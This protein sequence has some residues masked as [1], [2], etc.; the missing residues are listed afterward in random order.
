MVDTGGS[1]EYNITKN[2]LLPLFEILHVKEIKTLIITHKDYDHCGEIDNLKKYI[3]IEEILYDVDYI[4]I[5]NF[6]FKNLNNRNYDS[7]NDNSLV[8]YGIYDSMHIFLAGDISFDVEKDI[9]KNY[10]SIKIDILKVAHHG[11][12]YSTSE[13]F[14]QTYKPYIA[15]LSYGNNLYGHPSN[16]VIN[17]LKEVSTIIYSTKEDGTLI[18]ACN[19]RKEIYLRKLK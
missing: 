17:R 12:K 19:N 14:L 16:E 6:D 11:S 9:I 3:F 8:L 15:I 7:E 18:F 4:K 1:R 2:V 5:F 13:E 10:P